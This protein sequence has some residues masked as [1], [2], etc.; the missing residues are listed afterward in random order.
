MYIQLPYE[1]EWRRMDADTKDLWKKLEELPGGDSDPF[2]VPFGPTKECLTANQV[3]VLVQKNE[4][5]PDVLKHLENCEFCRKR[6]KNLE[7]LTRP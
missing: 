7:Q 1:K 5:G 4:G 2:E 3:V 6:R